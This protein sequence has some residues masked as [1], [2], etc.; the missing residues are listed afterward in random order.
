MVAGM[1]VKM[2]PERVAL[3][4]LMWADDSVETTA[5]QRVALTAGYW[6]DAKVDCSVEWW[7]ERTVIS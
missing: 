4:V 3:M 1:V 5:E 6:D 7:A 2:A